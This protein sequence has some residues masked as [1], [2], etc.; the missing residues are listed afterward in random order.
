MASSPPARHLRE[1][2][3]GSRSSQLV[4]SEAPEN[5]ERVQ[6]RSGGVFR[7]ATDLS[8]PKTPPAKRMC[9]KHYYQQDIHSDM[10]KREYQII[11]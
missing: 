9:V 10:Y 3:A 6:D 7:M 1:P 8:Y 11:F 4:Q 2:R 5:V